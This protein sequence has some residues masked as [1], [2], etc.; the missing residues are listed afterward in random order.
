MW[1]GQDGHEMNVSAI[2]TR[3]HIR[4][5]LNFVQAHISRKLKVC[6]DANGQQDV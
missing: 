2:I 6:C 4:N 3:G 5:Y 1:C